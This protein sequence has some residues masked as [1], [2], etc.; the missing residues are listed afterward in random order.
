MKLRFTKQDVIETYVA[1]ILSVTVK[2]PSPPPWLDAYELAE[3]T[4]HRVVE[5]FNTDPASVIRSA[6]SLACMIPKL[7]SLASW[8]KAIAKVDPL[9]EVVDQVLIPLTNAFHVGYEFGGVLRNEYKPHVVETLTSIDDAVQIAEQIHH[10]AVV[11]TKASGSS[12]SAKTLM[13]HIRTTRLGHED[14]RFHI[15]PWG[16]V[17]EFFNGRNPVLVL[18]EH[19]IPF[20]AERRAFDERTP[21]TVYHQDVTRQEVPPYLPIA[22]L[23]AAD[24]Q[25]SGV[26]LATYMATLR[27]QVK[28]VTTWHNAESAVSQTARIA[29]LFS[30]LTRTVPS[31]LALP[32]D[33]AE[34]APVQK[35]RKKKKRKKKEEV[36]E[37]EDLNEDDDDEWVDGWDSGNDGGNGDGDGNGDG[38]DDGDDDEDD[39]TEE[40]GDEEGDGE[41]EEEGEEEEEEEEEEGDEEGDGEYEEEGDEEDGDEWTEEEGDDGNWT[42]EENEGSDGEGVENEV[43]YSDDADL[44]VYDDEVENPTRED[45][46]T[47][48]VQLLADGMEAVKAVID[49]SMAAMQKSVDDAQGGVAQRL[50]KIES[51]IATVAE[52]IKEHRVTV[53]SLFTVLQA[54]NE[55]PKPAVTGA[56]SKAIAPAV[57]PKPKRKARDPKRSKAAPTGPKVRPS[58]SKPASADPPADKPTTRKA[59]KPPGSGKAKRMRVRTGINLSKE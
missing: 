47:A 2:E 40:E 4:L 19:N 23:A 27:K 11:S 29:E 24:L 28:H 17:V 32:L 49:S 42:E 56:P 43:E 51:A 25:R 21:V 13:N 50:D 48:A 22:R 12:K 44:D 31:P 39:W 1:G 30:Q 16:A 18:P 53:D 6:D 8:R 57:G 54:A 20:V 38:N 7:H 35:R 10:H 55:Q 5:Q 36:P 59:K 45:V 52:A 34:A 14:C 15:R 9:H 37:V 26:N 3:H 33:E 41:Y 58:G 46:G